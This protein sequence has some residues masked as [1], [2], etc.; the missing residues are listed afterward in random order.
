M[1]YQRGKRL[2][3]RLWRDYFLRRLDRLLPAGWSPATRSTSAGFSGHPYHY[4]VDPAM[5][6]EISR[7]RMTSASL[8]GGQSRGAGTDHDR[9]VYPEPAAPALPRAGGTYV[10]PV[11]R[12]TIMRV[13]D[14]SDGTSCVN[15]YSYWPTFNLNSTRFFVSCDDTPKLYRFDPDAFQI[16]SKEPMFTAQAPG[17]G[18]PNTED[19]TWSGLNPNVIICVTSGS[20]SMPTT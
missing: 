16:L 12:T 8:L 3:G 19:L 13:T 10:D 18:W 14:E 9:N 11:F 4:R 15:A 5:P 2:T 6:P 17:G 1:D 7:P 20:D